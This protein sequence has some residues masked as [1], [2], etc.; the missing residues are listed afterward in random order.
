MHSLTMPKQS[1]K[2]KAILAQQPGWFSG[3]S[4]AQK[5]TKR[6]TNQRRDEHVPTVQPTDLFNYAKPALQNA[7]Y[8]PNAASENT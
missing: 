4:R 1:K 6:N 2:L 8:E 3:K 5:R 7:A